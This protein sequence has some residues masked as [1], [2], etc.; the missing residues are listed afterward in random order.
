MDLLSN[1]KS[2]HIKTF[3]SKLLFCKK[4]SLKRNL[5]NCKSLSS[6]SSKGDKIPE[7][8]I[9]HKQNEVDGKNVMK[10]KGTKFSTTLNTF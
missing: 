4:S 5:K 7:N 2:K 3:N 9:D 1:L 6:H 8:E 10:A